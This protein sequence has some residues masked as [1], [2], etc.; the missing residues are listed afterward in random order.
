MIL[1]VCLALMP[2]VFV[3]VMAVHDL[4]PWWRQLQDIRG[5]PEVYG[6]R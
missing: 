2:V 5:L 4:L 1:A 3:A 6:R